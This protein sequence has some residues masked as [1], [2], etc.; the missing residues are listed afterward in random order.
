MSAVRLPHF[1]V[2]SPSVTAPAADAHLIQMQG[3]KRQKESLPACVIRRVIEDPSLAAVRLSDGAF[4]CLEAAGIGHR[5]PSCVD[6]NAPREG[7]AIA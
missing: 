3:L 5:D 6:A 7:V 1:Y 4:C 2:G